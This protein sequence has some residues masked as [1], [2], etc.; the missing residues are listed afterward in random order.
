MLFDHGLD[1]ITSW[2]TGYLIMAT[3]RIGN[4][5]LALF[6]LFYVPQFP[7]Y[8]A[9]WTQYHAGAF[10]LGY[11]NGIDEGLVI[12]ELFIVSTAFTGQEHF[13]MKPIPGVDFRVSDLIVIIN[14]F[15][16]ALQMFYFAMEA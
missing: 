3:L 7:F 9:M 1:T 4:T 5:E 10:K 15:I 14:F 2:L 12:I 8:F 6:G 13:I 11:I 16:I